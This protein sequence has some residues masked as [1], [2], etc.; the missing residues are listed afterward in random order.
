MKKSQTVAVCY[1]IIEELCKSLKSL[2]IRDNTLVHVLYDLESLLNMSVTSFSYLQ[3]KAF[4]FFYLCA[5]L[6]I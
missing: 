5:Y 2:R 3:R 4:I 6:F 1:D